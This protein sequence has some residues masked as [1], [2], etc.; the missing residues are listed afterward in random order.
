MIPTRLH[1]VFDYLGGLFLIAMPWIFGFARGG[2][3]T[4]VFVGAGALMIVL[5]M[6]TDYECGIVAGISM[7]AHLTMDGLVGAFL[8]A[9]PWL[10]GF[11][12]FVYMPH[13]ILGLVEVAGAIM[14]DRVP[15]KH[16]Y[17]YRER[18][19]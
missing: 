5:A 10:F 7:P 13:V 19:V 11:A 14:T 1:G 17:M 16:A 2:A 15:H 3:E 8:A 6:I 12:D 18:H 9:S 4:W